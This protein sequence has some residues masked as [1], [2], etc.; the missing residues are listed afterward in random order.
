MTRSDK[1][2]LEAFRVPTPLRLGALWAATMLCYVYG[3]FFG[4]FSP[5]R[6]MEMNRGI[7]GPLG[8]ATPGIVVA[9]SLMM[10]I[11]S[12]MIYLSLV[13]PPTIDR[14]INILLGLAYTAIMLLTMPGAPPFYLVLGAIEVALT[15]GIV[16]T[17]LAWPHIP[18]P[19]AA[20]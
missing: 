11:P 14:W 3:D 1:G 15:I 9:V 8:V 2:P 5:G 17:A 19:H 13:L 18:S 16:V 7:M 10:A 12:V 20:G 6:V 4:L